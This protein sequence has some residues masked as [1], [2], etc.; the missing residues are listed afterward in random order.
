MLFRLLESAGLMR[1][2][3]YE[4][5][6][7]GGVVSRYQRL[8]SN[9]LEIVAAT[10]GLNRIRQSRDALLPYLGSVITAQEPWLLRNADIAA[11]FREAYERAFEYTVEPPNIQHVTRLVAEARFIPIE[12]ASGILS[13]EL[14]DVGIARFMTILEDAARAVLNLRAS[15][16]G[17]DSVPDID[18]LLRPGSELVTRA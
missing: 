4:I 17:F 11:R 6:S 8:R 9:G 2:A 10:R 7:H 18:S 15:C 3:D 1:G 16:D 12:L 13:A 14:Q 5:V